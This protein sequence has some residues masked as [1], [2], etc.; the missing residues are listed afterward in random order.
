MATMAVGVTRLAGAM[1]QM[2]NVKTSDFTRLTKNLT[3]LA[4]I[5]IG[6]IRSVAVAMS[7]LTKSINNISDANASDGAKQVVELANGIKQLGYGSATKAVENIPK[8]AVAMRDLMN[9]LSGA[10][11]VSQNV[12]DMTNALAK[13]A[14]TGS[15][16]GS[17]ANALSKSL[18]SYSSSTKKAHKHSFNLASAIGKLYASYWMLFRLFGL[19]GK[20]VN[21]ASDLHEVDNVIRT[22]F[23]DYTELIDKMAETSISDYGISELTAKQIASRFQAMGTSMGIAQ[24]KMADMSIQLTELAADMASFYNV[25]AKEI[26]TSLQAIF[27]GETEP[28]RKYGLDLTNA[29]IQQWALKQGIDANVD[30]MSYMTKTLLRYQYVMSNTSAI[31]GD[32][33]RTSGSWA[34]QIRILQQSFSALGSVIGGTVINAFKPFISW[35]NTV[36]VKVIAFVE[37]IANAL[38]AIFGW[39]LE[40]NP[41]GLAD[42]AGGLD[43][44]GSSADNAANGLGNATDKAKELKRALLGFD[45][46]EK[47]PDENDASGGGPGGGG[48]TGGAGSAD[49][50]TAELVKVDSILKKYESEIKTLEGLGQYIGQALINAMESINW[51]EVYAKA[52][53]FGTGLASFLNGLF[54][55]DKNGNTVLGSLGTTIAGSI[56]TALSF[57]NSFGTTFDWSGF[58]AS[59][60]Q[61]IDNF[62]KT[63]D[64]K[65]AAKTINVWANGILDAMISAVETVNWYQ[66]GAD[67]GEFL[68][69]IDWDTIL[70][71][72]GKLI[73]MAIEAA[74]KT[75]KS[76]FDAAPIETAIV[77]AI[78]GL[79]FTGLGSKLSTNLW[80]AIKL[81]LGVGGATTTS[82]GSSS[83][84]QGIIG[85]FIAS[86]QSAFTGIGGWNGLF[87]A[88]FGATGVLGN[89]L[90]VLF[91]E[92][93]RTS[94]INSWTQGIADWKELLSNILRDNNP[95][96]DLFFGDGAETPELEIVI[97]GDTEPLET[98]VDESVEYLNETLPNET[99]VEVDADTEPAE[100]KTE[101]FRKD[102]SKKEIKFPFTT[103]ITVKEFIKK[104]KKKGITDTEVPVGVTTETK[105]ETFQEDVDNLVENYEQGVEVGVIT[106]SPVIQSMLTKMVKNFKL[107]VDAD[108]KT[109]PP[110]IQSLLDQKVL[111]YQMGVD[112]EI[113]TAPSILQFDLQ[114]HFNGFTAQV[115]ANADLKTT[116]DSIG[117]KFK[118]LIG[119]NAGLTNKTDSIGSANKNLTGF[120]AQMDKWSNN[121]TPGNIG[122]FT[123]LMRYWNKSDYFEAGK[124]GGFIALMRYW[125]K[126]DKF[127]AGTLGGFT[128][129]IS[130]FK[131]KIKTAA[132]IITGFVAFVASAATSTTKKADG[133]VFTGG[134]WKPI[135]AYASGGNPL[136]GQMFIAREAGP[137]LVGT[138][139]GHTAVMN[140]DQI[141]SSVSA[142]VYQAVLA[143][144]GQAGGSREVMVNVALEGD[145]AGIFRVVKQENDRIVLST[146]QPAL[147]T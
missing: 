145:A 97:D 3:N 55:A 35:L 134:T 44:V 105:P 93:M 54:D 104:L 26:G 66:V 122:G 38:G 116:T 112:A 27:T 95:V 106:P 82:A 57:L 125:N 28:L 10:P 84:G 120:N 74:L 99:A 12:I 76:S 42:D 144:M 118:K 91:D 39:T 50:A 138:L 113:S 131:D 83:V 21:L 100:T 65:L 127:E 73:Y 133:G 58:G 87:N 8:L 59:I 147:L 67:I 20:S 117:G 56:N 9:T 102:A 108:V 48:G 132:K 90:F 96:A 101:N 121:V 31:Q 143:A 19:L 129:N 45:E 49:G 18:F 115:D 41:G 80:N 29:S 128:A 62:F 34:N 61:G 43:D 77:T 98:A 139:G 123:A 4:N 109:T 114:S 14:R 24:G 11:R 92:Q 111:G 107:G 68:A 71:K 16:S 79:K 64:L 88:I 60:G 140:N 33:A 86:V 32:F 137:E 119:F 141:V 94:M 30:S 36:M 46:I 15:A 110:V 51:D 126:S 52:S 85:S 70:S 13:L 53:G 23:G 2:N 6:K 124:L 146:G 5:D 72:I 130:A 81:A 37:T 103:D 17:A 7:G 25:D 69:D 136:T 75:W 135:T 1:Q 40:I 63:T 22:T 89:P 78:L 47:L 142:G